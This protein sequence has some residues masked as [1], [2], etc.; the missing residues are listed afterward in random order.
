MRQFLLATAATLTLALTAPSGDAATPKSALG[1]VAVSPDGATVAAAGDNFTLYLVDA[2]NLQV[3][4]RIYL[5]TN[6]QELY[7]SADGKTLA[8]FTLDDEVVLYSTEDWKPRATIGNRIQQVAHAAAAD[9]LVLL[10]SSKRDKDNNYETP[11]TVIALANGGVKLEAVLKADVA[12]IAAQPDAGAFIAMTKQVKDEKEEK[13]EPPKDLSATE[14]K[15]FK[16]QHDGN[17]AEIL[18]LDA[19]GSETARQPSWFSQS[20]SLTGVF[21]GSEAWFLGY[22]NE[23]IRLK[24]DGSIIDF[25]EGPSSYNYGIGVSA[26]QTQVALGN[27]RT[28]SILDPA[29]GASVVFKLD[30]LQGW[31]EY[32][33]DLAFAPDGSVFAG[34][35]S[36]RLVHIGADGKVIQAAPIY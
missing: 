21:N 13:A 27:L 25:F 17:V 4:Q 32:I 6:P 33:K 15:N 23:N 9:S 20:G 7:Y 31:P 10:G 5:G 30:Q 19:S 35:T 1:A 14:K 2:A 8:V 22:S 36:Y 16:Q 12:A 26:D 24:A 3:R 28:G 11:I 34:T 29:T 18:V